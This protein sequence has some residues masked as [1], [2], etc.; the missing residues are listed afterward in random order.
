MRILTVLAC[1]ILLGNTAWSQTD[2]SKK[3][4]LRL[5]VD[6]ARLHK[7]NQELKD[8]IKE[9]MAECE[10]FRKQ[11]TEKEAKPGTSDGKSKP[12]LI[13]EKVDPLKLSGQWV[14]TRFINGEKFV[15]EGEI[16]DRDSNSI[17]LEAKA[18]KSDLKT[19]WRLA[20]S[21]SKLTL[22]DVTSE[23]GVATAVVGGEGRITPNSIR[24][25][26]HTKKFANGKLTGEGV[27]EFDLR[28]KK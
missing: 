14:G 8:R 7:E 20:L 22:I 17:T 15:C 16:V 28:S 13:E 19:K 26:Y 24:F 23:S 10:Q 21:G 6:N 25:S 11:L 9:L 4:I 12:R 1:L 2:L 5:E 27:G 18:V 3:L